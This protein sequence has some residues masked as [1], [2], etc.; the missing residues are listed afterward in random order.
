M[1]LK[2]A[3]LS[4]AFVLCLL[5]QIKYTLNIIEYNLKKKNDLSG[6]KKGDSAA[7]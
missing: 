3:H 7:S 4:C 1:Y 2:G 5:F 6:V